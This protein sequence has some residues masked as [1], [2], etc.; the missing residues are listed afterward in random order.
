MPDRVDERLAAVT[1]RLH[2][3]DSYPRGEGAN[4]ADLRRVLGIDVFRDAAVLVGLVPRDTGLQVL[5]TLRTADLR[6]HAGQVSFPGGGCEPDDA[7]AAATALRETQEETGIDR[8]LVTPL[9]T[10]DPLATVSAFR[11]VP[12]VARIDAGYIAH[13]DPHEVAD[14]F[15]VPFDWLMQP[16]NL[17]RIEVAMGD[18]VRHVPEFI[19]DDAIT[20]HRIWGVTAMILDNLRALQED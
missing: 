2:P 1:R 14:V 16:G 5:L 10:L 9:G 19:R 3:L 8:A 17:T 18:S 6:Q 7:D 20:P 4:A 13:P 15:E 11:V 12:V